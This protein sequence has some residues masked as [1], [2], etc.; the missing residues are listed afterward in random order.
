MVA[1]GEMT[2]NKKGTNKKIRELSS[3]TSS[4]YINM[5]LTGGGSHSLLDLSSAEYL[6]HYEYE[7]EYGVRLR[8]NPCYF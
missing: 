6:H 2:R 8:N 7:Y 3:T 1:F 4:S 5:V